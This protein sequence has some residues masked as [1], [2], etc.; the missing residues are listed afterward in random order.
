MSNPTKNLSVSDDLVVSLDYTL[1]LDDGEVIDSSEGE[2]PLEYLHGRGQLVP[3]L[4]KELYGMKVG[5]SKSVIVAPEDGY[6][7]YDEEAFEL[8]PLDSFPEDLDLAPGLELHMRDSA[9]GHIVQAF[10][11]E[12]RDDAVL[13][14]LNHPLAGEALHFEVKITSLRL[15][16]HEE[17]DH[18]HSHGADG[19]HH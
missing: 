6:G 18:G 19:H 9:S 5:D 10:V 14:D 11:A 15:A 17:L 8:V 7:E 1:R 2:N 16:T 13:L 12:I 3:G 4:E